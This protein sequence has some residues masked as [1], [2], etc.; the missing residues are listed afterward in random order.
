MRFLKTVAATVLL[1]G[2]SAMGAA[3]QSPVKLRLA[4]VVPVADWAPI[5]FEKPG[6]ARHQGKSYVMEPVRFQGTPPMI[7]AIATAE[8][9]IGNLAY[10]SFGL[11]VENAG[12][13]DL[14]I[15]ADEFQ[16]GVA[17]Y[18]SNE[19]FVLK[20][21]PVKT[22]A[23]LKGKV[24]ASNAAGSAVDIA[25]RAMLRKNKL[26]EKRD[27]TIVE[28]AFPNMRA[29]LAD[30]KIDLFSGVPP[31]SLDP[32]LLQI[33][34]PLFT[35]TDAVGTTQMI[36]WTVRGDFLRKNRAA[37]VDFLEDALR[38]EHWFTDPANRG[39]MLEIA[40]RVSGR[41]AASFQD[42]LFT[43]KDYYRAPDGKPNLAA[44]QANIDL[45]KELG[46]VKTSFDVK[47]FADLSLVEEA[48]KRLK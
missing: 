12:L 29:M 20:D 17:G 27:V 22:V 36:I 44:L 8:L 25:M 3:A 32:A 24:L 41:P 26:D 14:R 2:L 47:K 10:S 38:A 6:I 33:A 40:A 43:R 9:E 23:D 31:F 18:Y 16:D 45:Q 21:G 1:L 28:A 4:Y 19:Y 42:W 46:F 13:A 35:Q 30:R 5:L 39:E 7:N 34:R 37:L 15:I 48:A 11:A